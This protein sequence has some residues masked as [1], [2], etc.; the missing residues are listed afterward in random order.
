M[1]LI[2]SLAL[3]SED[4][5]WIRGTFGLTKGDGVKRAYKNNILQADFNFKD[6]SLG[7]NSAINPLYQA[8]RFADPKR[9]SL[10][11][12]ST[13]YSGDHDN[14]SFQMGRR[15]QQKFDNPQHEVHFRFGVPKF[16]GMF[17][18]FNNMTD[19]D[20][21]YLI[22]HGE[23]GGIFRNLG[24]LIG[25]GALFVL[26]PAP[27]LIPLVITSNV[28]KLITKMTQTKYYSLKPTPHLYLQ[29]VQSMA[30]TQLYWRKLIPTGTIL[31]SDEYDPTNPRSS[32]ASNKVTAKEMYQALPKIWKAG[33]RFDVFRMSMRYQILANRHSKK[34]EDIYAKSDDQ[35]D[36]A[37]KLEE[38]IK[39]AKQDKLDDGI[40][41]PKDISV[42][43][44]I[45]QAAENP[46]YQVSEEDSKRQKEMI[47]KLDAGMAENGMTNESITNEQNTSATATKAK[48]ELTKEEQA[49]MGNFWGGMINDL[50]E[51]A[52][53]Q[54]TEG[55]Q[56]ITFRTSGVGSISDSFSN[57]SKEPELAGKL[58]SITGKTRSLEFSLQEG[59]TGFDL[60][61]SATGAV[62][63]LVSGMADAV[64]IGGIASRFGTSFADIPDVYDSSSTSVGTQS[65][66]LE[67]RT[68][69]SDDMS[70]FQDL[71]MPT[72]FILAGVLPRST[73]KESWDEPF[74]CEMYSRGRQ[75]C[76]LGLIESVSIT[77]GGDGKQF[78]ADG[79][80]LAI[81]IDVKVKDLSKIVAMPVVDDPS[82]VS[83]ENL[84][85]DYMATLGGASLTELTYFSEKMKFGLNKWKNHWK[86]YL[87]PD[88]STSWA[89][90]GAIGRTLQLFAEQ[91]ALE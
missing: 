30:N 42:R 3:R 82:L 31:H 12:D 22:K 35:A 86:S 7:G 90:S 56:W 44:M 34:L 5:D 43:K 21:A 17:T 13:D 74:L 50:E 25:Y 28:L 81:D 83:E 85:T 67:L 69:Y 14:G 24:K 26:V 58:N 62:K 48:E 57:S 72:L 19:M 8:T 77:R 70:I 55:G 79:V 6:T 71:V 88:R 68:P 59:K 91:T 23:Y 49:Q 32:R 9:G 27:I 84:F 89:M 47:A 16:V 63:D 65:I 76:R 29:A 51:S 41:D 38:Y 40:V 66:K 20:T 36:Y 78:R 75:I 87:S 45:E 52:V 33:D 1:S 64:N 73:G 4:A 80:A 10:F 60:I 61:D 18:Y 2:K 54:I 11:T 53:S 39:Q 37:K 15:Y 46:F